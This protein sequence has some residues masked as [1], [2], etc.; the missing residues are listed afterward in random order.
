M[1]SSTYVQLT[2][3][4]FE[5]WLDTLKFDWQKKTGKVGVYQLFITDDVGI[6]ISSSISQQERVMNRARAAIHMKMV[7][8]VTG[9]TLNKKA[10]GQSHFKRTTNWRSS[11][12]KGIDRIHS[13]YIR[14]KDFYDAIAQIE[15]RDKYK[16]ETIAKIESIGGWER[17]NTLR[18]FHRRV[19]R[20]G[21]LTEKQQN[22]LDSTEP[23]EEEPE[24]E[25][26]FLNKLRR[27]YVMA[28]GA[29]DK[30]LMDFVE[31][32]GKQYKRNG[33]LSPKQMDVVERA[34]EKHRIA[35]NMRVARL[36]NFV[37]IH[38]S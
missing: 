29:N 25:D 8:F 17:N 23:I 32:V 33:R 3:E 21:I 1:I 27:L 9:Q 35:G 6:E 22:V 14:A 18:D 5:E 16:S 12:E 19:V 4:D 37:R 15:N 13:A 26:E 38:G 7:S 20:G 2:R 11:L 36:L 24:V 31:S 34:M 10:Q 30:W 28:R